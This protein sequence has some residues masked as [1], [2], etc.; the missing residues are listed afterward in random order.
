[1]GLEE[2]AYLRKKRTRANVRAGNRTSDLFR[3]SREVATCSQAT[4]RGVSQHMSHTLSPTGRGENT[5]SN[6]SATCHLCRVCR[7][8]TCHQDMSFDALKRHVF[9]RHIQ[10]SIWHIIPIVPYIPTHQTIASIL[11]RLAWVG[12]RRRIFFY[13]DWLILDSRSSLALHIGK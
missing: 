4:F 3:P 8:A 1:M 9:R 13:L 6:M 5:Y 7:V 2:P 10:L 11:K 12:P